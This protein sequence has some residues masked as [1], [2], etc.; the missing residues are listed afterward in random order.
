MAVDALRESTD[1]QVRKAAEALLLDI[2]QDPGTTTRVPDSEQ[3]TL[4]ENILEA[5]SNVGSS[6]AVSVIFEVGFESNASPHRPAAA[7]LATIDSEDVVAQALEMLRSRAEELDLEA[8]DSLLLIL[9]E[10]PLRR[11]RVPEIRKVLFEAVKRVPGT[12]LT[13]PRQRLLAK[14]IDSPAAVRETEALAVAMDFSVP[15]MDQILT[16]IRSVV[17]SA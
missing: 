13:E 15:P 9:T 10:R 3:A 12:A 7:A 5:L 16:S 11:E 2:L 14:V 1:P 8:Q 6:R 4:V 17:D